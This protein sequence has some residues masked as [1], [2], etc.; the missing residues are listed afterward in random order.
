[1]NIF[2]F[3]VE[4]V[5]AHHVKMMHPPHERDIRCKICYAPFAQPRYLFIH[6]RD[7]HI[8]IFVGISNKDGT[9]TMLE[10]NHSS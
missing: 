3:T 2:Q 7:M 10:N 6:M 4:K 8:K 1:M 5:F 9:Q